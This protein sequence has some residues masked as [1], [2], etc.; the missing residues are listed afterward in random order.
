MSANGQCG[1]KDSGL[2]K[3]AFHGDLS[4]VVEILDRGVVGPSSQDKHGE[5]LEYSLLE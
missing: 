1:E 2:H 3:A 5:T 4:G